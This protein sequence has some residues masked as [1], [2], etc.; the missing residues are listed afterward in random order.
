VE[1][2]VRRLDCF[3]EPEDVRRDDDVLVEARVVLRAR[4]FPAVCRV[5]RLEAML[6]CVVLCCLVFCTVQKY[7]EAKGDKVE[8]G[9]CGLLGKGELI[10]VTLV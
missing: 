8:V 9:V 4:C 6:S 7:T 1:R 10:R 3:R 5:L 2:E